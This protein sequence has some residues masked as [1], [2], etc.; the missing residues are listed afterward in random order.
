MTHLSFAGPTAT[1]AGRSLDEQDGWKFWRF[2][3][4]VTMTGE[5]QAVEYA[6]DIQDANFPPEM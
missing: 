5:E 1:V 4:S 6:V 3:L 2:D